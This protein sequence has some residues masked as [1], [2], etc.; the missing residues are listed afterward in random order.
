MTRP[1]K[2]PEGT[3]WMDTGTD[4]MYISKGGYW[5][6]IGGIQQA[7]TEKPRRSWWQ[8]LI[9]RIRFLLAD[10]ISSAI[11]GYQMTP[12]ETQFKELHDDADMKVKI[13]MDHLSKN[14]PHPEAVAK[15]QQ[16]AVTAWRKMKA[17]PASPRKN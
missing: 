6:A 14:N 17:F 5:H 2:A 13:F 11:D 7:V 9:A 8:R 4:T 1:T 16:A 10:F 12:T 15:S 3:M